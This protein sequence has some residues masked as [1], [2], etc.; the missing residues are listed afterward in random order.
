MKK[1]FVVFLTACLLLS[2]F[3]CSDFKPVLIELTEEE[4]QEITTNEL[5]GAFDCKESGEKMTDEEL[6]TVVSNVK[7]DKYELYPDL[8]NVPLTATLYKNGKATSIDVNDPRLIGIINLHNNAVYYNQYSYTQGLLNK[9]YLSENVLHENFRL[10]LTFTPFD[11]SHESK[12]AFNVNVC[13]TIIVTN[14]E[15]A[16]IAHDL[17]GYENEENKYPYRAFAHTPFNNNYP[18]LDLFGF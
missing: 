16:L 14:K 9:E 3:G 2:L 13:D 15:F 4:K 18:W 8:H 1:S 5:S 10:E 6:S 7:N 11:I 17:P 12:Y